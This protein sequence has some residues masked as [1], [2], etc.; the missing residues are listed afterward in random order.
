MNRL[1]CDCRHRYASGFEFSVS[2]S[3]TQAVTGV[4][5]PSGSGKTTL[6]NILAGL[7]RPQEGCVR[8]GDRLLL[9]TRHAVNLPPERRHIGFVF[10]DHL[11][12]PHMTV[13]R[14][15]RYGER[16]GSVTPRGASASSNGSPAAEF[17]HVVDVL[18]LGGLLGRYPRSLSGGER[19]RV[20]LGRALLSGPELLLLDEPLAAIDAE[21]KGRVL[22]YLE[23]V[24][25]EW[26]IPTIYVSHT[27]EEVR[28]LC[29]W[30]LVLRQGKL[31]AAGTPDEALTATP[32]SS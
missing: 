3:T 8:L 13:A 10:Q 24:L 32:T 1:S 27:A 20:A 7:V 17:D 5:G 19:Q 18:E 2:F 30:V 28:Q 11:L 21:L 26:R 4:V 14:N 31:A 29:Q 6:L 9:D 12:F 15:L 23:R 16:R 22:G 25:A